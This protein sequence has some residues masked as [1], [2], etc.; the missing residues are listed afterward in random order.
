LEVV[1]RVG[2]VYEGVVL[3]GEGSLGVDWCFWMNLAMA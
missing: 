1:V 2:L 3:V